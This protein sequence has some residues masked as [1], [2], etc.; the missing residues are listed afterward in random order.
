MGFSGCL[1]WLT[2][3]TIFISFLSDYLVDAIEGAAESMGMPV[4]FISVIIIPIVGNAAEHAA[5]VMFAMKNKMD[6]SL[7]VAI[8]SSTQIA[9]FVIPLCI[10]AGWFMGQPLDLNLHVFETTTFI[11]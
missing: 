8:G 5:A 10:V 6:I 3:I 9:L 2:I 1:I 11:M 4:A 7:G